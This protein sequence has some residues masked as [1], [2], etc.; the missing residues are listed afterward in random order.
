[1]NFF[2]SPLI[3]TSACLGQRICRYNQEELDS[4]LPE[5]VLPYIQL[6]SFCPEEQAGL[7]TPRKPLQT[8]WDGE[9]SITQP[10][11]HKNLLPILEQGANEILETLGPVDGVI[12]KSKSPS[13]G[14]GDHRVASS[15]GLG[16]TLFRSGVFA[17]LLCRS[18]KVMIPVTEKRLQTKWGLQLW[19]A[20]V[21]QLAQL[22]GLAQ[23]LQTFERFHQQQTRLLQGMGKLEVLSDLLGDFEEYRNQFARAFWDDVESSTFLKNLKSQKTCVSPE[24]QRS[25]DL[26]Q[27]LWSPE[28]PGANYPY[29]LG[30]FETTS[31]NSN[32]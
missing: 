24:T 9:L 31:A 16:Q 17:E 11:S 12:L 27:I 20:G 2:S 18:S 26:R 1:M 29:P 14:L 30:I 23:G 10:P 28:Q 13:C 3:A 22:K 25:G 7:G 5:T 21:F 32:S 6:R 19:L 8:R 4:P 15:E